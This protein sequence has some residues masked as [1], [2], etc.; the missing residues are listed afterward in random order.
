[1]ATSSAGDP[2]TMVPANSLRPSSCRQDDFAANVLR[3][4]GKIF[5]HRLILRL[6]EI[7]RVMRTIL[8]GR[9]LA[10]LSA[11]SSMRCASRVICAREASDLPSIDGANSC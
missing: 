1:M 4:L 3:M 9:R 11:R 2:D 6:A 7:L 10:V 8:L 5:V